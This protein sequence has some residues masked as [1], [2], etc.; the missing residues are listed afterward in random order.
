VHWAYQV[1]NLLLV[2]V[3]GG[4]ATA[5]YQTLCLSTYNSLYLNS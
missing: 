4:I 1:F 2:S 5:H 3:I